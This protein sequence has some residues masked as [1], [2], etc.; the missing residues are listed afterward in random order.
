MGGGVDVQV[1]RC[2]S[3]C[4]GGGCCGS[5]G[6]EGGGS[7]VGANEYRVCGG[8]RVCMGYTVQKGDALSV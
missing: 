3:R 1:S 8:M 7:R 4:A 6:S 5:E 2:V